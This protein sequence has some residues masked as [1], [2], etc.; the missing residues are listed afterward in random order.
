MIERQDASWITIHVQKYGDAFQ[1]DYHIVFYRDNDLRFPVLYKYKVFTIIT[2]N[3]N[4]TELERFK[5]VV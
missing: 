3:A 1:L 5:P 2:L 4:P